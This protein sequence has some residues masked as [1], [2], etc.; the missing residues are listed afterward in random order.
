MQ[1]A[2]IG[3]PTSGKTTLFDA[4]TGRH[5][6]PGAYAAP[7]SVQV[8]VVHVADERVD[9]IFELTKPKKCTYA[10]LEFLDIAGLFTGDKP[11][12]EAVRAMRYSDGL[13][14]VVRA[15]ES[16]S[17]AHAKGSID[18]RRDLEEI[19]SDLFVADL[20]IIER[21]I[22]N[23][24][25][26]VRKPTPRQDDERAR[27]ALLERCR[28]EIDAVGALGKLHLTEEERKVLGSYAFLTQKPSM[29]VLN[30]DDSQIGDR[31]A[32]AVL[33]EHREP[34]VAVCAAIEKE[35]L[36]LDPDERGPF[37]EDLGLGELS[38]Q[39]VVAA[40]LEALGLISFF[41]VGNRELRAWLIP[42]GTT[43]VEAAGKIHTDIARGFIR[44]EVVLYDDFR[45]LG[46]WKELRAKG[47][48]GLEGKDYV[49]QD[50]DIINVRFSV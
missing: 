20:D 4:I 48:I 10:S 18:P 31:S 37:L 2:I 12:P 23:L 44:A 6:E 24:Q 14:K 8:G 50:G 7:G 15:F 5:D 11:D 28:E 19:E 42:R 34:V 30:T 39:K 9:V 27:L 32:A 1:V 49:V 17:V 16:P 3:L 26:S 29:V 21:N 38:G 13:V 46:S 36:E 35:I 40:C 43:A 41:T 47:K 22:E 45:A 33:G 25:Q